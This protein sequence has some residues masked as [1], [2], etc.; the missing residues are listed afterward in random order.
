MLEIERILDNK[1]VRPPVISTLQMRG[2]ISHGNYGIYSCSKFLLF[3]FKYLV[4]IDD[5]ECILCMKYCILLDVEER[6]HLVLGIIAVNWDLACYFY[7]VRRT[8]MLGYFP[9]IKTYTNINFL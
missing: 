6:R 8:F 9:I 7:N 3:E 2:L 4:F 5:I 1:P